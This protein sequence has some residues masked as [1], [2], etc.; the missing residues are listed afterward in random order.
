MTLQQLNVITL[1][2]LNVIGLH[3]YSSITASKSILLQH[4]AT[5]HYIISISKQKLNSFNINNII[6]YRDIH[7]K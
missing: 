3:C 6:L 1:L 2:N 7:T 5:K 4:F